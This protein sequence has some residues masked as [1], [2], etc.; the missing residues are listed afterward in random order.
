MR[1]PLDVAKDL[2]AAHRQSDPQT[3][4]IKFMPS[5]N[6][7]PTQLLLLEVSD[8]VPTVNEVLPFRFSADAANG[9]D[10]P[11]VI[12]L[13]SPTDWGRVQQSLLLLP[14]G[15]NLAQAQDL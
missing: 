10:Y 12:I 11:S 9:V 6:Q 14:Q 15:W 5:A 3:K 8:S 7:S 2:A 4:I 13:L 1:L